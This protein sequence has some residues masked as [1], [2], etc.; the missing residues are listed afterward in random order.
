LRAPIAAASVKVA[1]SATGIDAKTAVRMSGTISA[2]GIR[3]K[4]A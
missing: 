3:R 2:I 1:G 4:Y